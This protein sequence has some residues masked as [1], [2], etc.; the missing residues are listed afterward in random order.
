M[1]SESRRWFFTLLDEVDAMGLQLQVRLF[2]LGMRM[3]L[4]VCQYVLGFATNS[5]LTG[6]SPL[7]GCK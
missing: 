6:A 1:T 2:V 3:G 5:L 4:C 7:A